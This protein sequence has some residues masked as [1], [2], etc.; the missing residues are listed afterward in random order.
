MFEAGNIN[1][2]H[3]LAD[4]AAIR[5]HNAM[6]NIPR[7]LDVLTAAK[8]IN[9][10]AKRTALIE[11][12]LLNEITG[13]KV[14]IKPENLQIT[15]SFKFRGAYNAI[16][17]LDEEQRKCGVVACSSGNHGQGIGEAARLLGVGATIVMPEDS[18]LTKLQRTM[19]S[20][21]KIVTYDRQSDDRDEIADQLCQ[22]HG[23]IFIHPY[24]N[25][26][27]IAGQGT[28]GLEIAQQ[29]LQIA[30]EANHHADAPTEAA[31][32]AKLDRV[33]V[34]TGGGGLA[35]GVALAICHHFPE[36]RIH[37]VEP[38]GF[39]DYRR[40]LLEGQRVENQSKSGSICDALLTQ[41]PGAIGFGINRKLL[42]EGFCVSDEEVLHA[43]RFAFS[44]LKLVV[45]PGGAVALA[46]LLKAG[47]KW[48]GET[49]ACIISGGNIDPDLMA[50]ALSQ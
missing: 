49:I 37:S 2:P 24:N 48:S 17:K 45:E 18:P 4:D 19:R 10:I 42:A 30:T 13:A 32:E 7:Y 33:L 3:R 34:C 46:A 39:D 21:A 16:S 44:E 40:S 6:E 20:G 22:Q 15:G 27:I 41:T 31:I 50:R 8:R 38:E 29:I 1:I 35:C 9:A 43:M 23:A 25:C 11:N 12:Q 5:D 28:T 26:D 14:F 47:K 36:A